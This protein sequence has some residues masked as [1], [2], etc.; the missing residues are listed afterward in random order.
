MQ[1]ENIRVRL[2]S[3]KEVG[4]VDALSFCYDISDTDFQVLKTLLNSGAKTED[5]LAEIRH[6]S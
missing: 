5:Q 3:G 6:L 4:L 2:P 1:V